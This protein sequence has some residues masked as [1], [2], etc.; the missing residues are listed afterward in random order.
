V[1]L[2]QFTQQAADHTP[3]WLA[4]VGAL[5]VAVIAAATAQW[6]LYAQ[7]RHDREL[8][9]L[10]ELR[11]L[12]DECAVTAGTASQAL[13]LYAGMGMEVPRQARPAGEPEDPPADVDAT[14]EDDEPKLWSPFDMRVGAEPFAEDEEDPGEF[15]ERERAF[16]EATQA[17]HGLYQRVVLRLGE[18][19]SISGA[20]LATHAAYVGAGLHPFVYD[21][22]PH[23]QER[24]DAL[25]YIV[26]AARAAH[27]AF[28]EECRRVVGSRI[29]QD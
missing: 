16:Y 18:G 1:L 9:D 22:D 21:T 27:F 11:E 13:G 29:R 19:H 7:L 5:A 28:L 2:A 25:T 17:F 26:S 12:L 3:A 23:S 24:A 4:F 15:G 6:R 20:F 8:K 14:G 10:D